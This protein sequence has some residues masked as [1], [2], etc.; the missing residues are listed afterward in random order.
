MK[1]AKLTA[2]LVACL[3]LFAGAGA[4][5]AS[6]DFFETDRFGI[7]S[8][9]NTYLDPFG[10]S[11]IEAGSHADIRTVLDLNKKLNGA[12]AGQM[13]NIEVTQPAG[14]Y[15]NPQA[16]PN[17]KMEQL[18]L[19]EGF[20]RPA[21]QVG[22]LNAEGWDWPIYN[23]V[24]APDQTA[25]LGVIVL[26][27]PTKIV[28]SAR[29][30]GDFGLTA[31]FTNLNQAFP[32]SHTVLT[33]WGSPADPI[34]DPQRMVGFLEGGATAGIPPKPF[35]SLPAR[36]EP[37]T[38][39]IEIDSWQDPGVWHKDSE[40]T[41]PLTGCDGL[42]FAPS[43]KARPTT[44]AADSPSGLEA[45]L[46]LPQ[47]TDD[48]DGR[49]TA[50]VKTADVALPPGLVIN[51]SGANGLGACGPAQI[52][53]T[54]AVGSGKASFTK[55]RPTCPD[56]ARIGS[57]EVDTPV[58][59]DPLKGKVFTM[60]PYDNPFDTLLGIYVVI[61][62]HG[63]VIKQA[64]KVTADPVSGRLSTTFDQ[65]PQLPFE[66]F[67]LKFDGGSAAVLRTP[68]NCGSYATTSTLTPWSAPAT[69]TI[70][71]RDEYAI[72]KGANGSGCGAP[73]N[74]PSFE[75]G[76]VSPIA[77]TY[78]P[79]VVNLRR[80][81]GTQQFAAVTLNP[82][83]G[84]VAKLA[85]TAICSDGALN[86]AANKS[87]RQEQASASCAAASEVGSVF[88]AAG[89]GPAP[90][91]APGKAYLGGP[92]KGAPLSIAIVTPAVAG[93]FD[94]GTIVVRT[95]LY[96]DPV[97][98][99]ITAKSDPI[100]AILKGVPLDVRAVSIRFD[101]PD[102]T[103]NPTSCDPTEVTGSLLSTSG[104]SAA[105][106]NRFQLAE[107]GRLKF[108]PSL[109]LTLKGGTKRA[110]YPALKAVLTNRSGDANIKSVQVALPH[111]EFLAQ[112]HIGT[113]C[114][115]VQWAADAC[116]KA[117]IYGKVSVTTPLL[118]YPLTGNVYLR[119]SDN[120]LP[121]LVPDLRGPAYQPIRFESAGKTDSI[122]GGIRNTFGLVPDVPFTKLTLQLQGGKKGLLVNSRNLCKSTNKANASYTAHNGL[123]YSIQPELKAKCGNKGKGHKSGRP[124]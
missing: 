65:I 54:S 39:T 96:L 26:S 107:C 98:A 78:K 24:P 95:A 67:K 120:P 11:V 58:F 21:A 109:K 117:S 45:D 23:L 69:P 106:N 8:F 83:P 76:S 50:M 73:A 89:A 7:E 105:L 119:S 102:F 15:G 87:G 113:V 61:E 103:L 82:P 97:T 118:S 101:K 66:D 93:P 47:N 6:A 52:G 70:G 33:L 2:A 10:G 124:G 51:P 48:P 121:D 43:L 34:H 20:C 94:L 49:T 56:S 14:L 75:A 71:D 3:A 59:A 55:N 63:L 79:F 72:D 1:S 104:S 111:S 42:A 9:S 80:D 92:Y 68:A 122:K 74:A 41:P 64:G 4:A 12:Q 40:T 115:R 91:N 84:L 88:A 112:E 62:G 18:V 123:S 60:T 38:T 53:L 57:V 19:A 13:H 85:N 116:P 29:T 46:K 30:D 44:N 17:C 110:D 77:G 86:A 32:L 81:D 37:V 27:V 90:F 5:S 99:K 114:T 36:C 25:V 108:K 16:I 28:V 100:P 31:N 35:L 22:V